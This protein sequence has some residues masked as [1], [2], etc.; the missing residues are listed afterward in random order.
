M[1][2]VHLRNWV[3]V[4]VLVWPD[5]AHECRRPALRQRVADRVWVLDSFLQRPRHP[6]IFDVLPVALHADFAA[7][8][9]VLNLLKVL[10][11]VVEWLILMLAVVLLDDSTD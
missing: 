2:E 11:L 4:L 6:Q 3:Q 5:I 8:N 9:Q 10:L 1:V 7:L